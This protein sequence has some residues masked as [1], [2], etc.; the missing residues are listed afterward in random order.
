M[1]VSEYPRV[2]TDGETV[3]VVAEIVTDTVPA[4]PESSAAVTVSV[5]ALFPAVKVVEVPVAGV[6]EAEFALDTDHEYAPLPP[7]AAKVCVPPRP[8][9][10]DDG[11][12]V[13]N[14]L[15]LDGPS[16]VLLPW[17]PLSHPTESRNVNAI[18]MIFRMEYFF[19]ILPKKPKAA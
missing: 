2:T 10:K 5:S 4:L 14:E 12:M 18:I 7:D 1:Y 3:S 9:D 13:T 17:S 11:E 6:R 15:P 19:F 16:G 8:M